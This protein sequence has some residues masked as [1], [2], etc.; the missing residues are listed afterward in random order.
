[1]KTHYF[2]PMKMTE[3]EAEALLNF[4]CA[5]KNL[6]LMDNLTEATVFDLYAYTEMLWQEMR[7]ETDYDDNH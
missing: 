6:G 5:L 3:R 2:L 7:L 4:C 1:M